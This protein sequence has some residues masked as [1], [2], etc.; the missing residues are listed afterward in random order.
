MW[1]NGSQWCGSENV[2]VAV[3][4]RYTATELRNNNVVI[5]S[6][7]SKWRRF[8]V[9]TTPL[10]GNV[11]AGLTPTDISLHVMKTFE[12]SCSLVITGRREYVK[13]RI[14]T[15]GHY[16]CCNLPT[17]HDVDMTPEILLHIYLMTL[18]F[19]TSTQ[20][21]GLRPWHIYVIWWPKLRP[22]HHLITL[23]LNFNTSNKDIYIMTWHLTHLHNDLELQQALVA[24]DLVEDMP[25]N[26][27]IQARQRII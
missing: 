3:S 23:A 15:Q 6:I 4:S 25:G 2:N 21:P 11:S 8:D 17:T 22:S 5:T 27:G 16:L 10:L 14:R 13:G 1:R 19:S 9:I 24:D 12:E 26:V 7:T 18:N 20:W